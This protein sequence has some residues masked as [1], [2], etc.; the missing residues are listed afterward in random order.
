MFLLVALKQ[1]LGLFQL[2]L[3]QYPHGWIV[4][5]KAGILMD[6]GVPLAIIEDEYQFVLGVWD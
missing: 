5:G 3:K 6:L 1:E 2:T 4:K